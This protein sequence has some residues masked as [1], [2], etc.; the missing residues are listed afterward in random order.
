MKVC[1]QLLIRSIKTWLN[2][3]LH[4]GHA[5]DLSLREIT[6]LVVSSSPFQPTDSFLCCGK[7]VTT[8][9]P[10]FSIVPWD[11]PD[12]E[13]EGFQV[14]KG[15][16][17][18]SAAAIRDQMFSPL[19]GEI[20]CSMQEMV[21]QSTTKTHV[22]I[23]GVLSECPHVAQGLSVLIADEGREDGFA[24]LS[25][26]NGV[27]AHCRGAAI[28][29]DGRRKHATVKRRW[30]DWSPTIVKP[31]NLTPCILTLESRI[32]KLDDITTASLAGNPA[33]TSEDMSRTHKR[34]GV[35][36][37]EYMQREGLTDQAFRIANSCMTHYQAT[38]DQTSL[39][40]LKTNLESQVSEA[41][42][43]LEVKERLEGIHYAAFF[44]MPAAIR[45]FCLFGS[46]V[47]Q[48]SQSEGTHSTF[49]P[50]HLAVVGCQGEV[51][52]QL[53]ERGADLSARTGSGLTCLHI[54]T[55]AACANSLE[56]KEK[57]K[58]LGLLRL[59][60]QKAALSMTDLNPEDGQGL[61]PFDIAVE[62]GNEEVTRVLEGSGAHGNTKHEVDF[63]PTGP[64]STG[65]TRGY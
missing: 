20:L 4:S 55:A 38:Q 56:E 24:I 5:H 48:P 10:A 23:S 30:P 41:Q 44:G 12:C 32:E 1:L 31:K 26:L 51:L 65:D 16:L 59:V 28:L 34:T 6:K 60:L 25:A 36:L 21:P 49:Q 57:E 45:F 46:S 7:A 40:Q 14:R 2:Q 18:V 3:L 63:A 33:C 47:N 22:L 27:T 8:D 15:Q 29:I 35:L 58:T 9:G 64:E 39:Q 17:I 42:F 43:Y 37:A 62:S 11:V 53:L 54:A 50:I 61:T 19:L 13:R 52:L